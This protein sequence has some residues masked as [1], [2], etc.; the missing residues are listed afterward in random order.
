MSRSLIS[1]EPIKTCKI[2]FD[3]IEKPD[4]FF[5]VKRDICLC[6]KC[7]KLFKPKFV[8]FNVININ[9]LAI[10]NYDNQIKTYLY[11][12]KGCFDYELFDTFLERYYKPLSIL[13]SGYTIVPIPSHEN[14]DKNRGFNHVEEIFSRLSLPMVKALR[15]TAQI[16]QSDQSK[17]D[18]KN[19]KKYME[20][21]PLPQLAGK[22]ILLVDDVYTTGSTMKAAIEL[23]KKLK[24]KDIKVL[25]LSKVEKGI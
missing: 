9:A 10:Y 4:F 23:V 6:S 14:D 19:I 8:S 15:K 24:P 3:K 1:N 11:Q 22:K 17:N 12:F 13:Y 25:V 2:C 7:R 21:I 20:L 5:L 18:R 16:K